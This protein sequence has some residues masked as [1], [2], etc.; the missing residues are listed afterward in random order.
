MRIDHSMPRVNARNLVIQKV[1]I[2]RG[3]V[4][5]QHCI[6]DKLKPAWNNFGKESRLLDHFIG[7]SRQRDDEAGNGKLRIYQR[8]KL[9]YYPSPTNAIGPKF[10]DAVRR[11]LC[12]RC[13]NIDNNKIQIVE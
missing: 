4:S 2:E 10:N 6:L 1:G 5:Y 11:H 7:Y 12:A 8:E 13:F 9:I 3:V